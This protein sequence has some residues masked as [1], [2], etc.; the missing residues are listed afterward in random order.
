MSGNSQDFWEGVGSPADSW[1]CNLPSLLLSK[2]N[3]W[4]VTFPGDSIRNE[5]HYIA[6][7]ALP[8]SILLLPFGFFLDPL[9]QSSGNHGI[10]MQ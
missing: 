8:A 7:R 6:P 10:H 5:K 3:V 1:E 9:L 2:E 4:K